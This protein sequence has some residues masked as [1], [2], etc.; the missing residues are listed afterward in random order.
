MDDGSTYEHEPVLRDRDAAEIKRLAAEIRS[1]IIAGMVAN[2]WKYDE[3]DDRL[4][5]ERVDTAE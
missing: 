5:P 3:G 1:E 2:G 4:L